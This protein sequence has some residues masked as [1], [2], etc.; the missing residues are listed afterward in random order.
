MILDLSVNHYICGDALTFPDFAEQV[1]KIGVTAVGITRAAIAEMGLTGLKSCLADNG[2]SVSSLNS[3]GYFTGSDPN[4][5]RFSDEELID[6]AAEMGA[7]VLCVI[8]GGIGAPPLP[9]AAAQ[10]QVVDGLAA[11]AERAA[12]AGVILGLEPIYPGDILT[13]GCINSCTHGLEIVAPHDNA[14]L[15]LDLYHS[16][17][18]PGL[19]ETLRNH[20]D[21][22]ALVQ[23]C[24]L[25]LEGGL[26]VGRDT[27]SEGALDL[28]DIL[29]SI[30]SSR[31]DGKL[32]YELFSHDL[33]GRNPAKVIQAFP[34]ELG[35][36]INP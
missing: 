29:S 2:L 6:A 26:V 23:L 15:I 11:L 1:S 10:R 35:L 18:D 33:V 21:Q 24:N 28:S 22:I 34:K 36:A 14:R 17:W 19:P 25:R 16:W 27:L 31:Y 32:E 12:D 7:D 20:A 8:T 3:A 9:V 5:V 30:A 4:P 13:K